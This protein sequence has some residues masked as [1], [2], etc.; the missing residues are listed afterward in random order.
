VPCRR[1]KRPFL[2]LYLVKGDEIKVAG[3]YPAHVRCTRD[4]NVRCASIFVV[5]RMAS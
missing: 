1:R 5:A 2:K 3:F 4:S